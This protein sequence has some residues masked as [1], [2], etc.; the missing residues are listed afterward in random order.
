MPQTLR[1]HAEWLYQNYI[2]KNILKTEIIHILKP[3][4][5]IFTTTL[6][7]QARTLLFYLNRFPDQRVFT[8]SDITNTEGPKKFQLQYKETVQVI[9][10]TKYVLK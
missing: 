10:K 2:K 7:S 5:K 6:K 4:Y 8:Y 1:L 9:R 3:I